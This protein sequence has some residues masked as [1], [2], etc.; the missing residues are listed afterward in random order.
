ML[1]KYI[2]INGK[3]MPNPNTGSFSYKYNPSENVFY[4]EAGD[5]LTEVV[6]LD[7]L[8]F[9]CT[10]NC[11]DRLKEELETLCKTASVSVSIDNGSPITGRLRLGGEIALAPNSENTPGTSGLWTVPVA[12]EGQ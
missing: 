3:Q 12:F 7:R 4:S 8:S 9:K 11:S 1:G 10:F 5:E 2:K 6:R